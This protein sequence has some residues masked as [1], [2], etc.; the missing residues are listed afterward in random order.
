MKSLRGASRSLWFIILVGL[1]LRVTVSVFLLGDTVKPRRDY[2]P[3]GYEAG[4]IAR[5]IARGEGFA[6]PLFERTGATAW[7]APVYPYLLAGIF[8]VFGVYTKASGVVVLSL[9]S[10]FSALTCWPVYFAARRTFGSSIGLYSAWGWALFPYAVYLSADRVW[11]T[12]LSGLLLATLF[13]LTLQLVDRFA[14]AV[15]E[16]SRGIGEWAGYGLLWGLAGLT[17]PTMLSTFLPMLGWACYRLHL[18]RRHFLIP[19]AVTSLALAISVTPWMVR[20]EHVFHH[21]VPLRD[22]FWLEV[23]VGNSGD[24]SHWFPQSAHPSTNDAELAE[25]NRM[26]EWKYMEQ[27][28]SQALHYIFGHPREFVLTVFRRIVFTWGGYWSFD[29]NYLAAE[30]FDPPYIVFS[31]LVS[32]LMLTGLWRG[33]R[34]AREVTSLYACILLFYPLVYYVTHPDPIYRHVIDPEIVILAMYGAPSLFH[35]WRQARWKVPVPV[36][37]PPE[38]NVDASSEPLAKTSASDCA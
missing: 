33:F 13:A 34:E 35:E 15:N 6:N 10:L 38:L 23:W 12:C 4:R 1:L 5:S 17:C 11:E 24:T 14:V 32:G 30:P 31:V 2:W 20:N 8:K 21:F 25:Y 3:F 37:S 19:A 22:N 16:D 9:D 36:E 7:M 29:R 28:R 18:Q 26:G 27:K